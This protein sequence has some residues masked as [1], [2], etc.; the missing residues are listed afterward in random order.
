MVDLST[1]QAKLAAQDWAGAERLLR[2][3]A[4]DRRAP[5][6]VFYNLGKVL[7]AAGKPQQSGPW[8]R[9]AV[10]GDPAYA[11]AWFELGRWAVAADDLALA[12]K[13]F[14]KAVD[15]APE[16]A[17][18]WRNLGRV[19]LRLGQ[20]AAARIAWAR[21][22]DGEARSALYRIAAELG[23]DVQDL[24]R[25]LLADPALRPEAMKALTRVAR[26]RVPLRFPKL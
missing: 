7:E 1:L 11:L 13:A 20:W 9:K 22:A 14:A 21:F 23:E 12:E 16:D 17:D 24:Q 3:A 18:A 6:Q 26:G 2:R 8:Y 10:A 4:Q 5:A 25:G 15:L 19:R